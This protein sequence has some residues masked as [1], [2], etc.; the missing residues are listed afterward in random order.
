VSTEGTGFIADKNIIFRCENKVPDSPQ[1]RR[2]CFYVTGSWDP[3]T[4]SRLGM[5]RAAANNMC[6]LRIRESHAASTHFCYCH[7]LESTS[8]TTTKV[9]SGP[10]DTNTASPW[11]WTPTCMGV[12]PEITQRCSS[13]ANVSCEVRTAWY[14]G[15]YHGILLD[16]YNH[17]S[18]ERSVV[19]LSSL[20]WCLVFD[21]GHR[22]R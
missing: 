7:G 13:A 1:A 14:K 22:H 17:G 5:P 12:V 16:T 2:S 4:Y 20:W 9:L 11:T 19:I 3:M 6:Y 15:P 18:V 10:Y 8:I 21:K